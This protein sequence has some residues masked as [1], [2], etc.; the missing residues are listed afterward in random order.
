VLRGEHDRLLDGE[1]GLKSLRANRKN[2]NMQPR[3]IQGLG[4]DPPEYT[5]D[6]GGESL[7]GLNVRVLR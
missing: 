2:E 7:S 5:R 3:E 1:K 6:L 4:E